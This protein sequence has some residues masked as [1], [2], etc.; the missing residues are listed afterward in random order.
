[1]SEDLIE[2]RI[3][4][5]LAVVRIGAYRKGQTYRVPAAEAERL[6]QQKGMIR[7]EAAPDPEEHEQWQA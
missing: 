6:I 7:V 1:M 2:L 5:D 4:D 3:P